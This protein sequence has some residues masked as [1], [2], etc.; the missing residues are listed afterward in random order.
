MGAGFSGV[1]GLQG[2]IPVAATPVVVAEAGM[3]DILALQG[4][5]PVQVVPG[6]VTPAGGFVSMLQ[7]SGVWVNSSGQ[8]V[9]LEAPADEQ[10]THDRFRYQDDEELLIIV[11][12]FIEVISC[13]RN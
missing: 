9:P 10:Y 11:Q 13:R 4:V 7:A 1:L 6:V 2:V 8:V 5:M 12:A 3:R